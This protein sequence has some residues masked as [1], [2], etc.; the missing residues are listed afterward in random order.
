M[1]AKVGYA[2]L[3]FCGIGVVTGAVAN[4]NVA[5]NRGLSPIIIPIIIPM[6][7]RK[8][9]VCQ[10]IEG[11]DRTPSAFNVMSPAASTWIYLRKV[12]SLTKVVTEETLVNAK[13]TLLKGATHGTLKYI[14]TEQG[15][16]FYR[17]YPDSGYAGVDQAT[18]QVEMGNYTVKLIYHFK[19]GG[20]FGA[21][22]AYDSY[23]DKK[24]CPKGR[25]WKISAT[26]HEIIGDGLS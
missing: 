22:D 17:Y 13:T 1:R 16:A 9:G 19:V 15:E 3:L 4:E 24:N 11:A 8:I 5:G 20:E 6:I 12:E 10:L 23:E 18:F 21:N 7:E 25:Y 14:A 2:A 26:Q